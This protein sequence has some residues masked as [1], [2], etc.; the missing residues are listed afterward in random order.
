METTYKVRSG[1][2]IFQ[3][4]LV[5]FRISLGHK[6]GIVNL[7]NLFFWL[8]SGLFYQLT[9]NDRTERVGSVHAY[10]IGM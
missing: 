9:E 4:A 8:A 6:L 3:I 7:E 2:G 1:S 5:L 10:C